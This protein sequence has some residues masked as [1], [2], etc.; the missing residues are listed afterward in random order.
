MPRKSGK[1]FGGSNSRK[2][3]TWL[4]HRKEGK[5]KWRPDQDFL[6]ERLCVPCEGTNPV[7]RTFS[8]LT[9]ISYGNQLKLSESYL[10]A[11]KSAV[12]GAHNWWK[13][14][15]ASVFIIKMGNLRCKDLSSKSRLYPLLRYR[16]VERP[17][18][19]LCVLGIPGPGLWSCAHK[20]TL[21]RGTVPTPKMTDWESEG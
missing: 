13:E 14:G 5:W 18:H 2:T 9:W 11:E 1:L 6:R 19:C 17:E 8:K 21:A 16:N 10:K 7:T 20:A 12:Y 4:R 15:W 3:E